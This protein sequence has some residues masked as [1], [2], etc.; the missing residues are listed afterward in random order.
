MSDNTNL[1]TIIDAVLAQAPTQA[2]ENTLL[3]GA[4]GSGLMA[5]TGFDPDELIS[6]LS[7]DY[8]HAVST[9]NRAEIEQ[10]YG[11][12]SRILS[13]SDISAQSYW[14]FANNPV[15]MAYW[16]PIV[17]RGLTQAGTTMKI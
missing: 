7:S 17:H 15:S 10:N 2:D 11:M 16:L 5:P 3:F 1:N 14:H 8:A 4:P 12:I 9:G 13:I 6:A